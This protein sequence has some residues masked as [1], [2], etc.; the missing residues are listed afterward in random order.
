MA[1]RPIPADRLQ[2][3]TDDR[4]G[5]TA[6]LVAERRARFGFNDVVVAA[7]ST[8][9]TLLRDTAADPMIWFLV[10]MSV[11][12]TVIGDYAEA[13]VLGVALLPLMGMDAYLHR[14]TQSSTA[15]L[16]SRLAA[17]ATVIRDGTA[18]TIAAREV[19]PGDLVE[20][21]AG[22]AFPADGLVVAATD[23]QVDES[24]LTGES[25][26]VRKRPL[27]PGPTPPVS[28]GSDHWVFAGTRLLAGQAHV[29]IISIGAETLYGE[30]VRSAVIGSHARTPMQNAIARLVAIMLAGALALCVALAIIR[31]IQGHSL[32]DA[33]LSAAT[34]AIAAL[35]LRAHFGQ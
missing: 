35:Q 4:T 23:A 26:P 14:R 5:L 25:W 24:S 27:P 19:V 13:A 7:P 11:L 9:L 8:W 33:F 31:L 28:A 15:A 17:R 10:G 2:G 20:V 34:L 12:F 21:V 16:S 22:A 6:V 1:L 18:L 29:R 3:A 30:I 32:F